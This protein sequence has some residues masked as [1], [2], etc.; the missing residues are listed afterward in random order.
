MRNILIKS[1]SVLS[2]SLFATGCIEETFPEGSTQTQSQ[3]S[4]SDAGVAA[5]IN[6]IPTSLVNA[7]TA[8]H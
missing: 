6:A 8:A 5:L 2:V 3:V 4:K 7:G 1:L